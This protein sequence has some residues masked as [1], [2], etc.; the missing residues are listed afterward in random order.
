M[1]IVPYDIHFHMMTIVDHYFHGLNALRN[2]Q[3]RFLRSPKTARVWSQKFFWGMT[4]RQ[5]SF[6]PDPRRTASPPLVNGRCIVT[7]CSLGPA[8]GLLFND[9]G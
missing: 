8:G 6:A 9:A 1:K 5:I 3:K 2:R 7:C 4:A